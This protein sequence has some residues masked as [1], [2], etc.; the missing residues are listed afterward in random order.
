[1]LNLK[2]KFMR[3]KEACK[4]SETWLLFWCNVLPSAHFA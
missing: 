4:I 1:M 3:K 2:T